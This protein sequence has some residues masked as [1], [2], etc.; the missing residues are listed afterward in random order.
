MTI[1]TISDRVHAIVELSEKF[2]QPRVVFHMKLKNSQQLKKLYVGGN[3][4]Y[5]LLDHGHDALVLGRELE[6][7]QEQDPSAC[8]DGTAVIPLNTAG[9]DLKSLHIGSFAG[10]VYICIETRKEGKLI[11]ELSFSFHL[12][13][14]AALLSMKTM[15]VDEMEALIRASRK[16]RRD[17]ALTEEGKQPLPTVKAWSWVAINEQTDKIS[18]YDSYSLSKKQAL[19]KCGPLLTS[20]EWRVHH[21]QKNMSIPSPRSML[22][23]AT[24]ALVAR[25]Q[26]KAAVR[27]ILADAVLAEKAEIMGEKKDD[28]PSEADETLLIDEKPPTV[29]DG[30]S[31]QL[32]PYSAE[33][34][35]EE[36]E[37]YKKALDK[38]VKA[39]KEFEQTHNP[40]ETMNVCF[41]MA[42][43]M[44]IKKDKLTPPD[45]M[46]A[47]ESLLIM[48]MATGCEIYV[49][50]VTA[51]DIP[52]VELLDLAMYCTSTVVAT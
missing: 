45:A 52:T 10:C 31:Q 20:A 34:L 21:L 41:Q 30:T 27:E 19:A 36:S 6:K 35:Q 37:E 1:Y 38:A 17:E 8:V 48:Q 23:A 9:R 26:E 39:Y 3:A 2:T 33:G 32:P 49:Y 12:D 40:L 24:A 18:T 42:D 50:N 51:L 28:S 4:I 22:L 44:E 11:K 7:R 47:A 25:K 5:R 16:R 14:F 15:I 43:E 13:E 46:S 29:T